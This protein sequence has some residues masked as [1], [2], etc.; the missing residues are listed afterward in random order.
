MVTIDHQTPSNHVVKWDGSNLCIRK[1]EKAVSITIKQIKRKIM[2]SRNVSTKFGRISIA[3]SSLLCKTTFIV[4]II[5]K[6]KL[7]N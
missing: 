2:E 3:Y 1:P 7:S 6:E 4:A 5:E